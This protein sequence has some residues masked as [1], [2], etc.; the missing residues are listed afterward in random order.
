VSELEHAYFSSGENQAQLPKIQQE[1]QQPQGK[2]EDQCE[3]E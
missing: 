1:A 3:M 2:D